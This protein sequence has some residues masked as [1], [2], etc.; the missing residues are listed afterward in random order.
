MLDLSLLGVAVLFFFLSFIM[1]FVIRKLPIY[2]QTSWSLIS[3]WGIAF[4]GIAEAWL[5]WDKPMLAQWV[6][7]DLCVIFAASFPGMLLLNT[8]QKREWLE[9]WRMSGVPVYRVIER[10]WTR[11]KVL[12]GEMGFVEK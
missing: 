5:R 6:I 2:C 8:L 4:V 3:V 12:L 7:I 1:C 9:Y 10:I 11:K